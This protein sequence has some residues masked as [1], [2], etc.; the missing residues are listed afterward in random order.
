MAALVFRE[1]PERVGV[2][3]KIVQ[4]GRDLKAHVISFPCHGQE[5]LPLSQ[6]APTPVQPGP[7]HLQRWG[8]HS[9][10]RQC[11]SALPFSQGKISS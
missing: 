1:S 2:F 4:A 11:A 5:Y 8:S 6:V 7:E 3:H 10:S 9:F